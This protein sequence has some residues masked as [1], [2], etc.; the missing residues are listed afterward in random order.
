MAH[1]ASHSNA[2][3]TLPS[4]EALKDQAKRLRTRLQVDGQ[5]ISH[6]KS[7]ELVA[8]QMGFRD[9]NTLHAR[10]GNRPPFNPYLLGSRV[11]GYYLGQAFEAEVLGVQSLGGSPVRYRLTLHLDQPVDVVTFESFSAFRQRVHCNVDGTGRTTEKTS[12]GRPQVELIW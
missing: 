6:S 11:R 5:T 8:A 2:S 12:N 4:L 1:T 3:A 7:L 9:W 10:L